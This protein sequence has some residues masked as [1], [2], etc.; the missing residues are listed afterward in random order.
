MLWFYSNTTNEC[1]SDP[2]QLTMT[3]MFQPKL[4]VRESERLNRLLA[5]A[6]ATAG[7]VAFNVMKD[8][9]VSRLMGIWL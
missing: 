7:S 8:T 6:L 2:N 3:K 1:K 9:R 4:S 5:K